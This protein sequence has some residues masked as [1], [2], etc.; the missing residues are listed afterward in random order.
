MRSLIAPWRLCS[1][2]AADLCSQHCL[3]YVN[4]IG[5]EM[6]TSVRILVMICIACV[7]SLR[8]SFL[9]W[10]ETLSMMCHDVSILCYTFYES[11]YYTIMAFRESRK[12]KQC[13]SI[14]CTATAIKD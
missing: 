6:T 14:Q 7:V 13:E 5:H 2:A 3:Q 4:K 9:V 8:D 1:N 12:S 10:H 11:S